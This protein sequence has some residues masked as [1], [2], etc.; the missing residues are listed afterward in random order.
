MSKPSHY[1]VAIV[2]AGI[3]GLAHAWE[4]H[5]RGLRTVVV[6]AAAGV[7]GASVRNFGHAC[8]TPQTGAAAVFAAEA[9]TR[10]LDLAVR[11]G[12]TARETGTVV[13]ARRAEELAVLE[14]H[15]ERHSEQLSG[16]HGATRLLTAAETTDRVPVAPG[17]VVGGAFLPADLQVDPRTAVPAIARHLAEQGVDFRWRTAATGATSGTLG[18]TRGDIA[19][20]TIVVA[21]NHDLDRL[22]PA[23]AE[24]VHL[25]RCRLHMLRATPVLRAPLTVPLLTGWSMLRYSGFAEQPSAAAL[26]DR[27][28]TELPEGIELDLNQMVTQHVD[29]SLI[30]G[31]THERG[32]DA[33][34]FE[35]E[36]GFDLV[37]RETKRLFGVRDVPV[38]ERWQGVYA[39]SP[40]REFVIEQPEPGVH[41]VTVASGIGMTTGLGIAPS[42]FDGTAADIATGRIPTETAQENR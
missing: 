41:V 10:W 33:V 38:V 30:L 24:R 35:S 5:R 27:L 7:H 20:H 21:T 12:F 37:I 8:I 34:P 13:V 31:D 32:V 22:F 18:T 17:A 19:A 4:A 23:V 15:N 3:V 1:D 6:D 29:G 42:T 40:D 36:R 16:P 9:R 25:V 26:R 14:E 11:A 28:A 2:G 39:S